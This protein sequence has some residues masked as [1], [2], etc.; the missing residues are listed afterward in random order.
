MRVHHVL[1]PLT[2]AFL[3][4]S[5]GRESMPTSIS[6]TEPGTGLTVPDVPG[7]MSGTTPS[8]SPTPVVSNHADP[9][10]GTMGRVGINFGNGDS[11]ARRA[12]VDAS[13]N[14]LLTGRIDTSNSRNT[15]LA[16]YTSKG[17]VD[18]TLTGGKG[19]VSDDLAGGNADWGDDIAVLADGSL[20][21]SG[22]VVKLVGTRVGLLTVY[23]N[24]T[25]PSLARFTSS[26]ALDT[27]FG[28]KG[29]L[30]LS[31][32]DDGEA[33][34]LAAA[35]DGTLFVGV[36]GDRGG[37]HLWSVLHLSASG[38]L[39][40]SWNSSGHSDIGEDSSTHLADLALDGRGGAFVAGA[41][42]S[43]AVVVHFDATGELDSAFGASGVAKLP[44]ASN[45]SAAISALTI[46]PKGRLLLCGTLS[47]P[48]AGGSTVQDA[49][50]YRLLS[51]GNADGSFGAAGAV[52]IDRGA[53]DEHGARAIGT[54]DDHV[55]VGMSSAGLGIER[56]LADGSPDATWGP[57]GWAASAT[58]VATDFAQDM[59]ALADGRWVVTGTNVNNPD[60][61]VLAAF[62]P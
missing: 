4:A 61:F 58:P 19:W 39:L 27:S 1:A 12:A 42:N 17:N 5:C 30:T 60:A 51:D 18:T 16:R 54:A 32:F 45:T 59:V 26:G 2:L 15:A 37:N 48:G 8:A 6:A 53:N 25:V 31:P 44:F 52:T 14:V 13:S 20:I 57:N 24:V 23:S 10:F 56:L 41:G 29:V 50:V 22:A 38:T 43:A 55:L 28:A 36:E 9:G 21:V 47:R 46:D 49:I 11:H 34:A 7:N 35:S 40:T 62:T 3:V 33:I